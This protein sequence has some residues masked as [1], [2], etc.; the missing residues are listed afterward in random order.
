MTKNTTIAILVVA[1]VAAVVYFRSHSHDTWLG[2]LYPDGGNL[3]VH[4][5]IGEFSSEETCIV[6]ALQTIQAAGWIS[7]DYECNRNCR[8]LVPGNPDTIFLCDD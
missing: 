5:T 1:I 3:L 4:Q 8:P 2:H 7:A 6:V